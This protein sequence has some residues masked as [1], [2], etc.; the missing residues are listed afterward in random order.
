M[1]RSYH[2]TLKELVHYGLIPNEYIGKI[3]KANI[4][5][6][7]NDKNIER[8]VGSEINQI[9]NNHAELIKTLNQYPKMFYAYGRLVKTL[10]NV[11]TSSDA[12]NKAI[13]D[14]RKKVVEVILKQDVIPINKAVKVF[15]ISTTTFYTWVAEVKYSCSESLLKKCY[16]RYSTQIT[17]IEIQAI[18]SSLL[19]KETLHW[20]IMSVYLNGI[21]N[22]TITVSKNTMYKVNR[23]LRIRNSVEIL[24]KKKRHKVGIRAKS[25]NQIW[26]ADITILKTTENKK[27]YI[28]LVMDNY[29]RKILSYSVNDKVTWKTTKETIDKAYLKIIDKPSCSNTMLIVDGGP[30]NTNIHIDKYFNRSDIRISKLIAQRDLAYSNSMI[31]RVNRTLKYRYLFPHQPRNLYHLKELLEYFIEDYN[32]KKPHGVLSGLTPDEAWR[33]KKIELNKSKVLQEAKKKRLEY[34]R[35]KRCDNCGF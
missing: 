34:N 13:R 2:T 7:K 16:G 29:S 31:E 25:P 22:G 18:K 12:Y 26:H 9:A 19:K 15:G 33:E 14:S 23:I 17:P 4:S 5:R 21:R 3:P 11:I 32:Y 20:S 6:W 30:E 24:R 10:T 8:F 28:Y 27:Y 35:S 1:R